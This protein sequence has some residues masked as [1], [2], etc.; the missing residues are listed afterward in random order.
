M[1]SEDGH[2]EKSEYNLKRLGFPPRAKND[3]AGAMN[4][5]IV[6]YYRCPENLAAFQLA[7]KVSEDLGYFRF[8]PETICYGKSSSGFRSKEVIGPLYDALNDVT[9]ADGTVRLPLDPNDILQ[10]LRYERYSNNGHEG[11]SPLGAPPVVRDF[12][13]R[14]RPYLPLPIRKHI[15]KA[16]LSDWTKIAFPRWPVDRTV[17]RILERLLVLSMKAQAVHQVPFVWFWPDG[18]TSCAIMTHD[19]EELAGRN[20]CSRLMDLDDSMGIKASFQIVPEKRYPVPDGFLDEIRDRGFEINIQDLNHDGHL[21]STQEQFLRRVERINEYARKY[22]ALGFRAGALYRNQAWYGALDFSYDMSVPSVAHLD[23]QRGGCCSLMPFFIGRILELPLTTI[24]DYSLFHILND[25]SI[26]LWK[27]Q[28]TSITEQHGLASFIVHP[29]YIISK[30][31]RATYQALL[32]LLA[33]LRKDRKI[34][35]PLPHEVDRWWRQRSEMRLLSVG[36]RWRIEGR[37][38]ERARVAF[39]TLVGD[40]LAFTVEGPN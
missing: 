26:E 2:D 11:Q 34:W 21:F 24:Q 33:R 20:F 17:E 32:E 14:L 8:G 40:E 10:N 9:A 39:A 5:A 23:P 18:A 3:A 13:Y 37:G 4:Q 25:Y 12:Y 6:E 19:V 31:A 16:R 27:Q 15:Q 30:R 29:D 7:G 36:N 1:I 38:S 22:R 35:I 28:L